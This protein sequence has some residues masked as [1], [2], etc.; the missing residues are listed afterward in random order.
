MPADAVYCP[1]CGAASGALPVESMAPAVETS[2]AE[3]ALGPGRRRWPIPVAVA[4]V[5]LL[6]VV[7]AVVG[8]GTSDPAVAPTTAPGPTTTVPPGTTTVPPTTTAA[9]AT[10]TT[11]YSR[12]VAAPMPAAA[13]VVVYESTNDGDVLRID[14][15]TGDVQRRYVPTAQRVSG[16]WSVIG[17]QGGFVLSDGSFDEQSPIFGVLDGPAGAVVPIA[18]WASVEHD[19]T[20]APRAMAAAEPDE[21]WAWNDANT[22]EP[23]TIK[24]V[25]IDGTVTAGPVTLSRYGSVFGADGPGAILLQGAGGLYRAV[26]DGPSVA[27]ERVATTVPLASSSGAFL[28]VDCDDTLQCH[29][30]VVDRT[31]GTARVVPGD[32]IDHVVPSYDNTLSADGRWLVNANF[33]S[34]PQAKLN[35]YDLT[36]GELVMQDDVMPTTYGL[37]GTSHS[38]DF[39]GDGQWLVYFNLSA[40]IR[41]WKVGSADKPVTFNVAVTNVNMISLAPA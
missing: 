31:T 28:Q 1:S 33:Q 35:V 19:G 8:G 13:G 16:P 9:P 39:T 34:D 29:L 10:T 5:A 26:V 11:T 21:V 18:A 38:A 14:L 30:S 40:G 32:V 25:R 17:R 4:A 3:V 24:R 7:V 22:G 6:V 12:S 36:T 2:S 20:I 37:L 23:I 27:V 41:L 15:G